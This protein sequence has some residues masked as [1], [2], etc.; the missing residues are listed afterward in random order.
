MDVQVFKSIQKSGI[1]VVSFF[2]IEPRDGVQMKLI[3]TF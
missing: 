1:N 3:L 2:I